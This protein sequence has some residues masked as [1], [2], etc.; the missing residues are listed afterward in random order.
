MAHHPGP[1]KA[2]PECKLRVGHPG[3]LAIILKME[4]RCHLGGPHSRAMT[5][6]DVKEDSWLV[7]H[8]H[9]VDQPGLADLG[10]RQ[11]ARRPFQAHNMVQA[12]RVADRHIIHMVK[13]RGP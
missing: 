2:R 11:D 13:T 4:R 1:R 10:R 8:R 6:M 5:I 9:I 3:G 7:L 12:L